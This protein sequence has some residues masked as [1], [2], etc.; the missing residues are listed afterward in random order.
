ML[1]RHYRLCHARKVRQSCLRVAAS[2][3]IAAKEHNVGMNIHAIK[4][5]LTYFAIVFGA[6]FVFGVLRVTLVVPRLGERLSELLEMPL[7][8]AVIVVAARW[9]VGRF[10]LTK[11]L[12]SSGLAGFTAL[13]VVLAAEL[14]LTVLIQQQPL[15]VYLAGR[16]PVS[17][18]VYLGMLAVF[19]AM[20]AWMAHRAARLE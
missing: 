19:A 20:P 16:D 15:S 11:A 18:S 9:L 1:Q 14:G 2:V 8:L 3:F 6:G 12:S 10:R 5:G 17:G 4:A 13:A 7:M